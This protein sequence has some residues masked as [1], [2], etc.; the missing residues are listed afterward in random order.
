MND[1]GYK[2]K[3]EKECEKKNYDAPQ[4]FRHDPLKSVSTAIYYYYYY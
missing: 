3:Q 2:N 1:E 4:F